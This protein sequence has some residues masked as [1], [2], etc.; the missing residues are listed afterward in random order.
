MEWSTNTESTNTDD[1]LI[2]REDSQEAIEQLAIDKGITGTFKVYYDGALMVGLDNL[3]ERVD[4]DK[5]VVSETLD[6]A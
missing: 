1:G 6:Q 3:P 2:A 4:M 5:V